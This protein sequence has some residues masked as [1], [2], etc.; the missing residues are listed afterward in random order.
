[1]EKINRIF[2]NAEIAVVVI[3]V[4]LS[5]TTV[6]VGRDQVLERFVKEQYATINLVIIIVAVLSM[7]FN[8]SRK[9][10][11][12]SLVLGIIGITVTTI[13]FSPVNNW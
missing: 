3:A 5:I 9:K 8:D 12:Y 13:L 4:L 2:F 6:L 7:V 11:I 1:M 10:R